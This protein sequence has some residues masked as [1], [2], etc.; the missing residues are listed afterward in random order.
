METVL[1]LN[2]DHVGAGVG[3]A[4]A[5]ADRNPIGSMVHRIFTRQVPWFK[6]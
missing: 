3:P 2:L 4:I 5:L 1:G 6:R